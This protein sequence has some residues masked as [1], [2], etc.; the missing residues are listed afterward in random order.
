MPEPWSMPW[1]APVFVTP[2]HA[3]KGV[4]SVVLPFQPAREVLAEILPPPLE[5][6]EGPGL[7]TMLTYPWGHNVR[8]H[9]FSEA[10]V[11]VPVVMEGVEANYVPYIYVTTDEAMIAGRETAGWPKKLADISWEREGDTF[12]GSVT[13]W[14]TT[15]L[16]VEGDLSAAP[17]DDGSMAQLLAGGQRPTYNYKL[18]PGP[19]DQMEVEEVTS[20]RLEI[21]PSDVSVGTGS[22]TT[23]SSEDDPL[24]ELV[25]AT[26]GPIVAMVSDNTI[27]AGEVVRRIGRRAALVG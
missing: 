10:V 8:I 5:P 20:T 24:G 25:P 27:P 21:V 16:T 22:I 12:R 13:R 7:V 6:G 18:I 2:P 15:I 26:S 23:A 11:L 1:S 3:W 19:G 14:G 17:T 9:P 4:R